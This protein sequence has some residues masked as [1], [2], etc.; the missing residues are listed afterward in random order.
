M[1]SQMSRQV[2]RG[3]AGEY[4]ADE[5][6]GRAAPLASIRQMSGQVSRGSVSEYQ[7]DERAHFGAV[8]YKKEKRNNYMITHEPRDPC[9]LICLIIAS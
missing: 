1:I 4:Q 8:R 6:R 7:A 5:G 2:S 9:P 3:S